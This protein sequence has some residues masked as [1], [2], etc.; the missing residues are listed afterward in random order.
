MSVG[1]FVPGSAIWWGSYSIYKEQYWRLLGGAGEQGS[2]SFGKG[3]QG[4]KGG[5][6]A[7]GGANA[8]ALA[9]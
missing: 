7:G 2:Q 1:L 5:G 4:D 3:G 9:K 8:K 6:D